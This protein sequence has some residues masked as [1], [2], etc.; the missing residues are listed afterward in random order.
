MYK[1]DKEEFE[2]LYRIMREVNGW[3]GSLENLEMSHMDEFDEIFSGEKPLEIAERIGTE[4]SSMDDYFYIDVYG[5]CISLPE[6]E[7]MELILD[8]REEIEEAYQDVKR[9]L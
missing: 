1:S 3:D 5:Q 8:S 7:A 2:R 4:F 6:R 9:F